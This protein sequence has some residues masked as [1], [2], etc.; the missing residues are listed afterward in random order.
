MRYAAAAGIPSEIYAL[1]VSSLWLGIVSAGLLTIVALVGLFLGPR[2]RYAD[3]YM[4]AISVLMWP[5]S[6]AAIGLV[7][8]SASLFIW[9]THYR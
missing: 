7:V 9:T 4:R 5:I 1:T 3:A 2:S 8:G 6:I